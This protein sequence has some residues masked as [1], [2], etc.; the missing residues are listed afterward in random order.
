[1]F[2][3]V[4]NIIPTVT[5]ITGFINRSINKFLAPVLQFFLILIGIN[6]LVDLRTQYITSCLDQFCRN[7]INSLYFIYSQLSRMYF[8]LPTFNYWQK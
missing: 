3:V 2:C 6:K 4:D 1:M 8:R 5:F 7:I